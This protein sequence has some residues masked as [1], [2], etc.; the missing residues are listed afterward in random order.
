MSTLQTGRLNSGAVGGLLGSDF[1]TFTG[2]AGALF[3]VILGGFVGLAKV[4]FPIDLALTYNRRK[5]S[6][7]PQ[8]AY[9][10]RSPHFWTLTGGAH[11][12]LPGGVPGP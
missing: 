1:T 3:G 7:R 11:G 2:F 10:P 6:T 5:C 9:R 8:E 4:F 12:P